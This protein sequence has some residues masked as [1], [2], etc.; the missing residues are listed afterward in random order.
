MEFY[1]NVLKEKSSAKPQI[2][3][4]V[5]QE[6]ESYGTCVLRYRV[7]E[8]VANAV[9]CEGDFLSQIVACG[10][11]RNYFWE[12]RQLRVTAFDISIPAGV[13]IGPFQP[14]AAAL[15]FSQVQDGA[16]TI[17]LACC[18]VVAKQMALSGEGGAL[19]SSL[20]PSGQSCGC[21]G[22]WFDG[23]FLD[24][25]V[26]LFSAP[27]GAFVTLMYDVVRA[28]EEDPVVSLNLGTAVGRSGERYAAP[29]DL[30]SSR[31][32]RPCLGEYRHLILGKTQGFSIFEGRGARIWD[33]SKPDHPALG[34]AD[35]GKA[36]GLG[37]STQP[38]G[39]DVG[40]DSN[41]ALFEAV[42]V[43]H[44]CPRILYGA[45]YHV[46][47]GVLEDKDPF[48]G[49]ENTDQDAVDWCLGASWF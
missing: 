14:Q 24:D 17:L 26:M 33:A 32:I 18:K 36:G 25:P 47:P 48:L 12:C 49:E 39:H 13:G 38:T 10:G 7:E 8:D 20:Y 28:T 6:P 30:T 29:L 37:V 23:H 22:K 1:L 15:W 2:S 42:S 40:G 44:A 45:G 35:G 43:Y 41:V 11:P 31:V 19:T 5:D 3:F 16:R 34:E 9:L 27:R 46:G 4:G 21:H